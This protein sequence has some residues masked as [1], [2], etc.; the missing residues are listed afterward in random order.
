MDKEATATISATYCWHPGH[1]VLASVRDTGADVGYSRQQ[2]TGTADDY[3]AAI[4]AVSAEREE[5]QGPHRG[6]CT[7]L[8]K[9]LR[10]ALSY[11]EKKT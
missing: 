1:G 4:T 7:R 3:R 8:L 11:L 6:A 10:G 5:S 9:R 2:I